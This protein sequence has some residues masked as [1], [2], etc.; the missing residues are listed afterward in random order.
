MRGVT[1]VLQEGLSAPTGGDGLPALAVHHKASHACA[2]CTVQPAVCSLL[3]ARGMGSSFSAPCRLTC[4]VCLAY[5]PLTPPHC[6]RPGQ[7]V[8]ASF[9]LSPSC[10]ANLHRVPCHTMLPPPHSRRPEQLRR[11]RH[12][13]VGQPRPQQPPSPSQGPHRTGRPAAP[14]SQPDAIY[15]SGGCARWQRLSGRWGRGRRIGS[16]GVWSRWV[17]EPSRWGTGRQQVVHTW[18]RRSRGGSWG[19]G[20]WYGCCVWWRQRV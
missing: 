15:R 1:K 14:P 19:R 13:R 4:I 10:T 5:P 18:G 2:V 7:L 3:T 17:P 12:G 20:K 6:R 9:Q 16:P 11:L 8:S